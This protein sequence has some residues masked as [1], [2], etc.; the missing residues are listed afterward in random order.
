MRERV[1]Q[2]HPWVGK[3]NC[4]PPT[5][6]L[7][8]ATANIYTHKHSSWSGAW[9]GALLSPPPAL[10]PWLWGLVC[11]S[12]PI[13][14]QEEMV[15]RAC[16]CFNMSLPTEDWSSSSFF[17]S[18]SLQFGRKQADYSCKKRKSELGGGG[19]GGDATDKLHWKPLAVHLH[20]H[21]LKMLTNDV[22]WF[23]KGPGRSAVEVSFLPN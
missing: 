21:F 16:L 7:E 20:S 10:L 6:S 4:F 19:G 3:W 23:A 17:P 5:R 18:A 15:L 2:K 12:R 11:V 22:K 1:F 8:W 14:R 13:L 9:L